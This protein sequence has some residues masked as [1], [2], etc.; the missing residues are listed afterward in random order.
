MEL[1]WDIKCKEKTQ[2]GDWD[3]V[4]VLG[5]GR[6]LLYDILSSTR[7]TSEYKVIRIVS[8]IMRDSDKRRKDHKTLR[9]ERGERENEKEKEREK[10]RKK[11]T[12]RVKEI[13]HESVGQTEIGALTKQTE[14]RREIKK[15]ERKGE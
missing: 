9:K 15:R 12:G 10:E 5:E 7:P 13:E 2:E 11:Q 6:S 14:S 3:V 4:D 8:S 1:E